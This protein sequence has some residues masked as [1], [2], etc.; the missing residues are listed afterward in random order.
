MPKVLTFYK[1]LQVHLGEL[2]REVSF[3]DVKSSSAPNFITAVRP[4]GACAKPT[5]K[6][7]KP[8]KPKCYGC[9]WVF[10]KARQLMPCSRRWES[11][12]DLS[13]G[14][15]PTWG[16]GLRA[17]PPGTTTQVKRCSWTVGSIK[18]SSNP[19]SLLLSYLH[20]WGQLKKWVWILHRACVLCGES[21]EW[22]KQI[23]WEVKLK[24]RTNN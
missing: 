22:G 20:A 10:L 21:L 4:F 17:F 5:S 18:L 16:T 7:W 23:K 12:P 13:V 2:I 9:V 24:E 3:S 14:R 6:S 11:C 15:G 8:F 19:P 1:V